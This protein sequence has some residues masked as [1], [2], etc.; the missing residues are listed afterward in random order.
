MK[1][2]AFL[3]AAT[4]A[5]MFLFYSCQKEVAPKTTDEATVL[6]TKSGNQAEKFNTFYGPQFHM[7]DGKARSFVTISHTGVPAEIGIELTDKAF[8]G[9]PSE[10]ETSFFLTLHQKAQAVTPFDHIEIDWNPHGHP[11]EGVYTTPHFDFHF[12]KISKDVQ[13]TIPEY[14]PATASLFDN[15]PPQG[16]LPPTYIPF[17]A[18]VPQM[19]KH[20]GD[21]TAEEFNPPHLFSKTFIYGTYNGEVIFY[22]PMVTLAVLQSGQTYNTSFPQPQNFSPTNT[23]YPTK[24]NIYSDDKGKHYISLSDFVWR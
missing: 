3:F 24:Y 2:K 12:Y 16:Y 1:R 7:G 22:E 20:W 4:T 23:Y 19:G 21:V 14:G 15:F 13:M 5:S 6:V 8:S 10:G 9:L 11:L 18:G 17:P